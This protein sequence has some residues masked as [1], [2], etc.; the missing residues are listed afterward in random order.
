MWRNAHRQLSFGWFSAAYGESGTGYSSSAF[1]RLNVSCQNLAISS[2]TYAL[3]YLRQ[4]LFALFFLS[5]V[6]L[7]KCLVQATHTIG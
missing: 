2:T 5:Y 3:S 4:R 6:G 7:L 1:F